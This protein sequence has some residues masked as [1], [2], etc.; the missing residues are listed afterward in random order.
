MSNRAIFNAS[1]VNGVAVFDVTDPIL[2][3]A[4]FDFKLNGAKTIIIDY[5]GTA[6]SLSIGA[7]FINS[8]AQLI[9]AE[10]IWNFSNQ[11]LASLNITSQFGG[12][13]LAPYTDLTNS[14]NI[15][16]GVFV[17]SLTQNGEIHSQP[18]NGSIPTP[19][20]ST[21]ILLIVAGLGMG[22]LNVYRKKHRAV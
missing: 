1:P 14:A 18:F 7:N 11:N 17:D 16:G 4:E 3:M 2:S 5:I 12:S 10:T 6:S 15:E 9:G 13:I 8:E 19:E 20:P 22:G 21:L